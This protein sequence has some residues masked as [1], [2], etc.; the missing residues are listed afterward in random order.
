MI[1]SLYNN[2]GNRGLRLVVI[3]FDRRYLLTST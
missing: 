1:E 3:S 2:S